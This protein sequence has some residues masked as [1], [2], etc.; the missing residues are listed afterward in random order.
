MN[1]KKTEKS[2]LQFAAILPHPPALIPDIGKNEHKAVAATKKAVVK[3][4]EALKKIDF[5]TLVI[6]SP[7]GLVGREQVPVLSC[8]RF[9]G[10]LG[11]FGAGSLTF[12]FKGDSRLAG[13]VIEM[14][15]SYGIGVQESDKSVLD[16]GTLVPLYFLSKKK[17]SSRILPVGISYASRQSLYAFGGIIRE[18]AEVLKK[19]IAIIASGDLSHRLKKNSP[20]GFSEVAKEFDQKVV[21]AIKKMKPKE[22]LELS[23]DLSEEAAE[24][25]VRPISILLGALNGL[26]LKTR[27]LS[28]EA[29]FGVGYLVATIEMLKK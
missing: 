27:V 20:Q 18:A 24:C 22:I 11:A 7:H 21:T 23:H 14:A 25:G 8:S 10:T 1:K 2:A 15:K 5:D 13:Q 28:Y 17:I 9:T 3:V 16:Y 6:I 19:K 4:F 26:S 12:S 29:P